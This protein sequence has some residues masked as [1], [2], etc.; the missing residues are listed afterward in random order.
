MSSEADETDLALPLRFVQRFDYT[1]VGEVQVR[2][3]FIDD[4]V[5][6]PEVQ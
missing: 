3:V 5:N 6:L 2:I 4:L 1:S